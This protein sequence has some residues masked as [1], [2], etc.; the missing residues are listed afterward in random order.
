MASYASMKRLRLPLKMLQSMFLP[1]ILL[2]LALVPSALSPTEKPKATPGTFRGEVVNPPK[3]EASDGLLYLRGSD[4]NVRRVVVAHAL[5]VF[6][7]AVPSNER[8]R[9]A[10]RS[11]A[12]GVQVRVTALVDA[13]SGEW[14]ASRV[15]VIS[16]HAGNFE[17][18]YPDDAN[19][20]DASQKPPAMS[21]STI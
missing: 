14:T 6:D 4:G 16:G 20:P 18:D 19:A 11:I 1:A 2:T 13:S 7:S 8:K 12:P 5:I 21:T 15:E 10:R 9:S 17:D 3:G